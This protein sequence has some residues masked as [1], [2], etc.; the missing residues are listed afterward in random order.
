MSSLT[1]VSVLNAAVYIEHICEIT[2]TSGE[3]SLRTE[4]ELLPLTTVVSF[5]LF[6]AEV[7]LSKAFRNIELGKDE[8][9]E[10]GSSATGCVVSIGVSVIELLRLDCFACFSL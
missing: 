10:L 7:A 1:C 4:P 5:V 8:I 3:P 9:G 6:I 2:D